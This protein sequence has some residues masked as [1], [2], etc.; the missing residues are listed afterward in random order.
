[1]L[2]L[3]PKEFSFLGPNTINMLSVLLKLV[4]VLFLSS[5]MYLISLYYEKVTILPSFP[6]K[7]LQ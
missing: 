3:F 7:Y 4:E 6:F 5:T 2:K 1:M